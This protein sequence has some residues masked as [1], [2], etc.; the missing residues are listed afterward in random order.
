MKSIKAPPEREISKTFK[1][2]TLT[3]DW[4]ILNTILKFVDQIRA[5]HSR[6][7]KLKPDELHL[8]ILIPSSLSGISHH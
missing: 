4:N 8:E 5:K 1:D 2:T 7:D 6:W 3:I